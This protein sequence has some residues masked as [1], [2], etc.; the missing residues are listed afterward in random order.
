MADPIIDYRARIV[1]ALTESYGGDGVDD[2][3][4]H[5]EAADAV[6]E[7]AR[8]A[9][10]PVAE[11]LAQRK[12]A[13][14]N[15]AARELLYPDHRAEA[16]RLL[17]SC[18]IDP[19]DERDAPTYPEL[20]DGVNSIANALAAAQVH[21]LLALAEAV[22]RRPSVESVSAGFATTHAMI[23]IIAERFGGQFGGDS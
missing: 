12:L 6:L 11:E 5:E 14:A 15:Q 3:R 4:H 18:Q 21:A 23:E 17:E 8:E 13:D 20:E 9:T 10:R 1:R 7:I 19:G 2:W 22:D 16:L